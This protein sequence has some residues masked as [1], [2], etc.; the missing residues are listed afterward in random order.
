MDVNFVSAVSFQSNNIF[1]DVPQADSL[2]DDLT[3]GFN[4]EVKSKFV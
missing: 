4:D 3:S 2:C 1:H